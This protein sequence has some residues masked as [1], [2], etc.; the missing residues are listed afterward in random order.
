ME[1]IIVDTSGRHMQE[2]ALFEEML[3]VSN[4]VGPDNIVFVMDASIGQACEAQAKAFKEKVD[5]GSV[6]ITK[7]DS[8]AKG[9]GALSAVAAT[10]S[11]VIFIGTGEHIHQFEPFDT[12]PFVKKLLGMGD[13]KGLMKIVEDLDIGNNEELYHRYG[14]VKNSCT[15]TITLKFVCTNNRIKH[16]EFTLRDMYEQFQNIMKMGPIGQVMGMIPGFREDFMT[17][18]SE[19]ESMARLKR[20]MTMMDSMNDTELDHKEGSKLFKQEPRRI[21]RISQGAGVMEREVLD[22]LTQYAKFAQ[23]SGQTNENVAIGGCLPYF[24]CF[25]GG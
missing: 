15:S 13:I 5:V 8:H 16:G 22:L 18:G 2:E 6:V 20:L 12:V 23:V 24:G 21:T 7:L 14:R 10:Q 4:A 3:A 1:I 9:G 11:P 19:E 25:K 17:K